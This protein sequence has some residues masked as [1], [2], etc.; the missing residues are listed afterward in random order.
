MLQPGPRRVDPD[1][2]LVKSFID[3]YLDTALLATIGNFLTDNRLLWR[4]KLLSSEQD[5][6]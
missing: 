2:R 3:A 5:A 4:A 1:A 6:A